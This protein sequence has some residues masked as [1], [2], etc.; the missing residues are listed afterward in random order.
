[1]TLDT[2]RTHQIRVQLSERGFAVLGDPIYGPKEARLHPVAKQLGR[3]ALHAK[4]LRIGAGA[5]PI[6]A[7]LPND[8]AEVL[9]ELRITAGKTA[10]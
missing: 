10:S 4:V 1:M 6:E 2:G 5:S 7:P 9:H 3:L 8:F